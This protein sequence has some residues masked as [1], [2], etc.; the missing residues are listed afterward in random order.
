MLRKKI[1]TAL[2]RVL[3]D[4][5]IP[6][7]HGSSHIY[8]KFDPSKI[9]KMEWGKGMYFS[10]KLVG[11]DSADSYG[12]YIYST[13]IKLSDLY[14]VTTFP[15]KLAKALGLE[16]YDEK[17]ADK[18]RKDAYNWY[19]QIAS[20]LMEFLRGK[21]SSDWLNSKDIVSNE[22]KKMGFDGLYIPF[23]NWLVLFNPENYDIKRDLDAEKQIAGK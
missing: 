9:K 22:I 21:K 8:D 19:G 3:A 10:T 15:T 4:S 5:T 23:R 16:N 1:L 7:Y 20:D 17:Y 2:R 11:E 14:D 13:N 6:I 12:E 18:N